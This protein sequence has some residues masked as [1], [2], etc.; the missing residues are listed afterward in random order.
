MDERDITMATGFLPT[1]RQKLLRFYCRLSEPERLSLHAEQAILISDRQGTWQHSQPEL[2]YCTLLLALNERYRLTH[3][4]KSR[5]SKAVDLTKAEQLQVE[6][7]KVTRHKSRKGVKRDLLMMHMPL[8]R[9]LVEEEGLSWREIA[10]YLAKYQKLEVAHTY[11][12][13]L[14]N[15]C[16]EAL[17]TKYERQP[18][19]PR[20]E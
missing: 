19:L 18:A 14:Y 12:N 17:A 4:G 7:I 16:R 11:V 10:T 2:A 9:K 1:R 6:Q 15:E 8:I 3:I 5:Q 20:E 13:R